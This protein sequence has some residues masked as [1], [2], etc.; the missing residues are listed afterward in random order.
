MV[1]FLGRDVAVAITTES[2]VA[3]DDVSVASGLCISGAASGIRFA[4][5]MNASTFSSYTAGN[6]LVEDLTGVDISIGAMD[7]DITY[8]GQRGTGKVE[9]KKEVSITLT[10]KKKNNVWDVIFN[11]PTQAASLENFSSNQPIGA[12]F[13][14]DRTTDDSPYIGDGLVNPKDVID[15][16]ST[17]V[18][19]GYRVHVKMLTGSTDGTTETISIPNCAI[20]GYTVSLNADGVSEETIEL[21]T[22]QTP[23]YSVGNNIN[24]TLTPQAD[25]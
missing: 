22:Q 17:N 6:G 3:A 10:H 15:S 18:C 12:R 13:G 9:Q 11:G 8:M 14:L 4:A 25:Y 21:S 24:N 2:T 23:L 20:T 7:E 5:D 19:Y 16:G 1:Y